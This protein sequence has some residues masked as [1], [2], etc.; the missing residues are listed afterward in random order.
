MVDVG[1]VVKNQV[2]MERLA[3]MGV[4]IQVKLKLKLEAGV[5]R[6]D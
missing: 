3:M 1:R 4:R 6:L 2:G 5:E